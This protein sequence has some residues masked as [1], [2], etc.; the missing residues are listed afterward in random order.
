MAAKALTELSGSSKTPQTTEEEGAMAANDLKDSSEAEQQEHHHPVSPAV[1]IKDEPMT[2][3]NQHHCDELE[4]IAGSSN[5]LSNYDDTR[6]TMTDHNMEEYGSELVGDNGNHQEPNM[7]VLSENIL[8][9]QQRLETAAVLMDISKKVVISPP[10]SNP[11]SPSICVETDPSIINS[12][13]KLNRRPNNNHRL[14]GNRTKF[15]T[16]TTAP[17]KGRFDLAHLSN[18]LMSSQHSSNPTSIKNFELNDTRQM[19]P[20]CLFDCTDSKRGLLTAIE[21]DHSSDSH[22][23]E[24]DLNTLAERRSPESMASEDHGTDAAT[25]QLWQALAQSAGKTD[26]HTTTFVKY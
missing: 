9:L 24:I 1:K 25:T 4:G 19:S 12:V 7:E 15:V 8:N 18:I 3:A 16:K 20:S 2:I 26:R 14:R 11:E 17:K 6:P 13:I 10:C 5:S 23:L 22:R 21:S